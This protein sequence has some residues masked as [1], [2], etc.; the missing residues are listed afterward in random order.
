MNKKF[1]F[2]LQ[3]IW[4]LAGCTCF[5][6][7]WLKAD[8]GQK[9]IVLERVS[10][11]RIA[12]QEQAWQDLF[13]RQSYRY[14]AAI[15]IAVCIGLLTVGWYLFAPS[16]TK[17]DK[18]LSTDDETKLRTLLLEKYIQDEAA[19]ETFKGRIA[20]LARLALDNAIYIALGGITLGIG[21]RFWDTIKKQWK[22]VVGASDQDTYISI[23]REL[24]KNVVFGVK[25]L[26]TWEGVAARRGDQEQGKNL[27]LE[28]CS[29][30]VVIDIRAFVYTFERFA[31]WVSMMLIS[32]D[33]VSDGNSTEITESMYQLCDLINSVIASV[34]EELCGKPETAASEKRSKQ[35]V[36]KNLYSAIDRWV[37]VVGGSLFGQDFVSP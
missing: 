31:A 18:A 29:H 14:K 17:K 21:Y 7:S 25:T 6:P 37:Y 1:L 15:G 3:S 24:L 30:D 10:A 4:L 27:L 9:T 11:E 32:S 28:Y 16:T 22:N 36:M 2:F 26:S 35:A 5:S 13:D 33:N 19:R 12:H 8:D 23:T 34:E 20:W